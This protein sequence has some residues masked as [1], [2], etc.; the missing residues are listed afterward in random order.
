MAPRGR[1]RS[2]GDLLRRPEGGLLVAGILLAVVATLTAVVLVDASSP[3]LLGEIDRW[4]RDL[5][6]DAPGWTETFSHGLKVLGSGWVMV[7]L[8][9]LVAIWLIARR[10]RYDLAAWLL[11]WVAADA[12]TFVMKP[13]IGRVRPDGT[14]ATSFPSGHAKTAAQVAVGL[15]LVVTSPWRSRA[16][17]WGIAAAWIVAMALS[18]TVL[19][20]HWLSDVVAG[21]LLGAACAIGVAAL[22]QRRRGVRD[23]GRPP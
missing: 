2:D 23:D 15:V 14:D 7:P 13:G 12:I 16:T 1:T 18:R 10:R 21:S 4:W 19:D 5:V 8:R 3:P 17:A 11:A 9:I 22:V 20:E 6:L